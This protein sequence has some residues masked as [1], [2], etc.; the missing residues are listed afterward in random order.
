MFAAA[1]FVTDAGKLPRFGIYSPSCCGR[2]YGDLMPFSLGIYMYLKLLKF[3][4]ICMFY[5][6]DSICG[7]R[8]YA[9]LALLLSPYLL[10]YISL[11]L[12]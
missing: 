5:P 3:V 2:S 8:A 12:G 6:D 1:A 7:E 10:L 9:R 11:T 4:V